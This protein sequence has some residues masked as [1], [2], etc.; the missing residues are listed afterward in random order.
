VSQGVR[1]TRY[2]QRFFDPRILKVRKHLGGQGVWGAPEIK[3]SN[4]A[5]Q[6]YLWEVRCFPIEGWMY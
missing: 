2:E 6:K 4:R 5:L 3:V 1:E